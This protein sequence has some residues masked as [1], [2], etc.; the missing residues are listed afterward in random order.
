MCTWVSV[1]VNGSPSEKF[2]M[3]RGLRQRCSLSPLLFKL[4]VEALP[5]LVYQ[6]ED[7]RWLKGMCILGVRE[8]TT[9]L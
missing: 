3:E 9:V 1:L 7:N 5:T 8:R 4:V 2:R 6:F